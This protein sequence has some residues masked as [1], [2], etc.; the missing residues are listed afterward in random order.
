MRRDRH[1][2]LLTLEDKTMVIEG[3]RRW[4][5]LDS[6]L[7]G[8]EAVLVIPKGVWLGWCVLSPNRRR[9]FYSHWWSWGY[10]KR[11]VTQIMWA[12][13]C[14]LNL[15]MIQG[16]FLNSVGWVISLSFVLLNPL[17]ISRI[18]LKS[19]CYTFWFNM[20]EVL[21]SKKPFSYLCFQRSTSIPNTSLEHSSLYRKLRGIIAAII[22]IIY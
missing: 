20:T 12:L 16:P 8:S 13:S 4:V 21:E 2:G 7:N 18:A 17:Y 15:L 5:L 6:N 9:H 10:L 3:I 14:L 22:F 1:V 11:S 19:P